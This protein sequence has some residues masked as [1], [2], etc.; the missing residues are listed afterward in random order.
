MKNKRKNIYIGL[1][2]CASLCIAILY[3]PVGSPELY[4]KASYYELYQPAPIAVVGIPKIKS[5]LQVGSNASDG[6]NLLIP[7]Q[8]TPSKIGL[9]TSYSV[10]GST[11]SSQHSFSSAIHNNTVGASRFSTLKMSDGAGGQSFYPVI[12]GSRKSVGDQFAPKGIF[13]SADIKS[14]DN[15]NTLRGVD[16]LPNTGATDPG[17]DPL[18][19]PIPVPDGYGFLLLLGVVYFAIKRFKL[20]R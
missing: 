19:P 8:N 12:S 20:S 13:A 14:F 11:S 16:Y 1:L 17:D 4:S 7:V 3:S 10:S 6:F 18:G 2:V 15:N 9:S 5:N